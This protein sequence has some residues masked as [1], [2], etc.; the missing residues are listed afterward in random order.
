MPLKSAQ[1]ICCFF[2]PLALQIGI[3]VVFV[4]IIVVIIAMLLGS[5]AFLNSYD[6]ISISSICGILVLLLL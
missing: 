5:G 2:P 1:I 4:V 6:G 3:V